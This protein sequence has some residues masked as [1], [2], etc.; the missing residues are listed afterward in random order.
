MQSFPDIKKDEFRDMM[1]LDAVFI[2]ELFLRTSSWTSDTSRNEEGSM[3]SKSFRKR[4]KNDYVLTQP[5][6][7]KSIHRDLLR[8]ENQLPISL[9][10][11]LY[12]DI[13]IPCANQRPKHHY[14]LDL[15]L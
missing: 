14:F 7:S 1:L 5:W 10:N 12:Y 15:A 13:L 4:H 8:L 6:L 9:L 11:K 3:D 2:M